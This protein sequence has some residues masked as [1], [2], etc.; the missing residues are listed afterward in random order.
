[1]KINNLEDLKKCEK[2]IPP[3]VLKDILQRVN[4]WLDT[5]GN[6]NDPYVQR[7]FI[8]AEKVS[9]LYSKGQWED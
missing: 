4:D 5:G 2:V 8:Y 9:N 1:M 7:Q 3:L 6:V